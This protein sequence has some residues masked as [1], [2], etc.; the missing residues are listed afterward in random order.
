M[1]FDRRSIL[2]SKK[3]LYT[4]ILCVI[5][6]IALI[7]SLTACNNTPAGNTTESD[8]TS[9]DAS[10]NGGNGGNNGNGS[11]DGTEGETSTN[12]PDNTQPAEDAEYTYEL[13]DNGD[14]TAT[15]KQT[16]D[17]ASYTATFG[18]PNGTEY[19]LDKSSGALSFTG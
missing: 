2:K 18:Y 11:T 9:A 16:S 15:V 3:T 13:T 8:G 6:A 7:V 14:G 10:G 5:F 17:K 1:I 12:V 19:S 4:R